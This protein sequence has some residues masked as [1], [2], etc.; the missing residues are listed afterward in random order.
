M[1]QKLM[2]DNEKIKKEKKGVV[3]RQDLTDLSRPY[4]LKGSFGCKTWG[5]A[6]NIPT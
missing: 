2:K 6:K 3:H 1:M 5:S 4:R